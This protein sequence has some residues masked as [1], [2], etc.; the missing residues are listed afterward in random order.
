MS[1]CSTD[2]P[3][4]SSSSSTSQSVFRNERTLSDLEAAYNA[5]DSSLSRAESLV[6]AV[7]RGELSVTPSEL[8]ACLNQ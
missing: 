1:H 3:P 8:R 5:W 4:L 6:A 2:A 7:S